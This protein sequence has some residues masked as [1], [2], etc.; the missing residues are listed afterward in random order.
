MAKKP[1][2]P[3][4]DADLNGFRSKTQPAKPKPKAPKKK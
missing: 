2:I 1:N 3:V 4:G